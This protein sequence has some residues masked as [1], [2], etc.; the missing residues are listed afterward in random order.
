MNAGDVVR[1]TFVSPVTQVK[2]G[3]VRVLNGTEVHW[4]R[5]ENVEVL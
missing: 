3:W 2:D 5:E 4:V 1:V